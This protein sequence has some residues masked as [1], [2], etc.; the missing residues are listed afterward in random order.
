MNKGATKEKETGTA[1]KAAT[2]T[3]TETE[4]WKYPVS[5]SMYQQK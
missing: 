5:A 2:E 3:E 1:T 4:G